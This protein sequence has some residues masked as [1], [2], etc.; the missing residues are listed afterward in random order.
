MTDTSDD[1]TTTTARGAAFFDLDRTLIDINSGLVW[2]QHERSQGNISLWQFA[3]ASFWTLLYHV[4]LIDMEKAFAEAVR[5]YEGEAW[6]DLERRTRDWF[7]DEIEHRLRT[8]AEQRLDDHRREG[9]DLVVLTNSSCFEAAAATDA[10][11]LDDW[12]A[13]EFHTDDT[14]RLT[15]DFEEPLCYGE[16]KVVRAREWAAEHDVSLESSYFY[17]DSYSD[18]PMLEAVGHPRVVDPDPRL[19]RHA[20][21]ED[22]TIE[23]W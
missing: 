19:S 21:S 18:L 17:S 15:G 2:A 1:T 22:W 9:H 13:N 5:H 6:E 8:G 16:G 20:R 3:R 12:L 10:W 11:G 23:D 14:G 4:S 7:H